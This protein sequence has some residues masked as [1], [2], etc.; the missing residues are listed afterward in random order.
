VSL[1][2]DAGSPV[3]LVVLRNHLAAIESEVA[4]LRQAKEV[5]TALA[6]VGQELAESLDVAQV[7]ERIVTTILRLVRGRRASL[8]RYVPASGELICVAAAGEAGPA[9]WLG[10]SL[11]PGEGIA[12]LAAAEGQLLW[13]AD[14]LT[15]PRVTLSAFWRERLEEEG[16]RA[17]VALPLIAR[18][19][20]VGALTL[21]DVAGRV[22]SE[23][24]RHILT[25]FAAQAA[26][27]L[28]NARLHAAAVRRGAELTAL[29]RASRA[30]MGQLNLQETLE[31]IVTEAVQIS[32]CSHVKVLL[33]DREAG[34]LRVGA[35]CG[36]G[37]FPEGFHFPLRTGLSARVARTGET[38]FVED[39][40]SDPDNIMREKD[41]HD[42]VMTYL[43]LPIKIRG[44]VLGVLTFNTAEPRQ[45]AQE[46]MAYFKAFADHAALAIEH[47]RLYEEAQ[48]E[49]AERARTE[50]ALRT[51]TQQLQ[52]VRAI[53]EEITRELDLR[54]VLDL[55]MRRAV[56]LVG[57]DTGIVRLWDEKA[58]L[59]VPQSWVGLIDRRGALSLR[60]GEAV[61]GAAAE[62][63]QGL[64][65]NDFRHSPYVTP[66]ILESTTHAAVL[67]VPLLYHD[68]L[69]GVINVNR[70]EAGRPFKDEDRQL[71]ALL[72]AQAA[73]AIENARLFAELNRSY[74][75][76]QR[77]QDELIRSAKLQ[78]LGQ[79]AAGIAHDLNNMLTAV[80]GQAELL[81]FHMTTP[82]LQQR[83]NIL[84]KAA[85]DGAQTVRRLQDFARQRATTPL[86]PCDLISL[87]HEA[88]EMTHPRWRD[89]PQRHGHV[90][91]LRIAPLDPGG[92][93]RILG[94]PTEVREALINL[95]L[96]AVDAMPQGGTLSLAARPA[97]PPI[98]QSLDGSGPADGSAARRV[99]T[100]GEWVELAVTDTGHG[101]TEEVRQRIF[102]PFFSTKGLR[103]TGLGLSVVYGIME[104]HGGQ[105]V[106]TSAPGQGTTVTL[107]FQAAPADAIAQ[108]STQLPPM[109]PRRILLV[110]DEYMVR[111]TLASLLR[112]AGHTVVEADSGTSGLAALGAQPIDL[113]CTDLGMP[114]MNGWELARALKAQAPSIPVILLTG[115]GEYP[116][117]EESDRGLVDRILGK[118][119]RLQDLQA[120]IAEL[121]GDRP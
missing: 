78:A 16:Y 21:N 101:M 10:R 93:P 109:V 111:Q 13:S 57:A 98:G 43:G 35:L 17:V 115:W 114:G 88:L 74:Q 60:L 40:A 38:V 50:S 44:E 65:V 107:R 47:A 94:H 1:P 82:E 26:L 23:G 105:I 71:L 120:A 58:A 24:D 51:R 39:P 95:I 83:L 75:D 61:A 34:V 55:I 81:R 66:L 79:M 53:G 72:A 108:P 118:P 37:P 97:R 87:V 86:A 84:A 54:A 4:A 85:M 62:R 102:D 90:I 112:G 14:I 8:F 104:R 41:L 9:K 33:L 49:L 119:A 36:T 96:N 5:A 12:G 2:A 18:G 20:V 63:R 89:E 99:D 19:T 25:V 11:G 32:G 6:E 27:A 59:L 91:E 70:E 103:G 67:A 48:R 92:L 77:A 30:V 80:L 42:G 76:L 113:V 29:L 22:F 15:D 106:V 68:R 117:G 28:E 31:R 45:Y 64:I 46:E 73:I 121:T 56:D 52:T 116:T 7:T 110:E 3:E 100:P 69:V